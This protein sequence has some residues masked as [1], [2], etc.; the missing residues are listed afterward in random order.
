[1]AGSQMA[2]ISENDRF[3]VRAIV[4]ALLENRGIRADTVSADELL[5]AERVVDAYLAKATAETEKAVASAQEARKPR[6][7]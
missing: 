5:E 4:G 6:P 3:R 2:G 1:M 7:S